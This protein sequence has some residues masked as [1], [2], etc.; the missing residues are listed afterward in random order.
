MIM[1]MRGNMNGGKAVGLVSYLSFS[2]LY[3]IDN[4]LILKRP[5]SFSQNS[6]S[7]GDKQRTKRSFIPFGNEIFFSYFAWTHQ[8]ISQRNRSRFR[9][10]VSIKVQRNTKNTERVFFRFW[11]VSSFVTRFRPSNVLGRFWKTIHASKMER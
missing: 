2:L 9:W 8:S 5:L 1:M 6:D 11:S 3:S 7:D 10:R 4:S